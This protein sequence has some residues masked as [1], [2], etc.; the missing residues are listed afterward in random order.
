[1]G[2]DSSEPKDSPYKLGNLDMMDRVRKISREEAEKRIS[3]KLYG[4]CKSGGMEGL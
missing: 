3:I 1:M 2:S 4:S